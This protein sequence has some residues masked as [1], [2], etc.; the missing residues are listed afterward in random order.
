PAIADIKNR[1][2]SEGAVLSMMSGSGPA[3]FGVFHSAKEAEKASR[4]FEDHW[5][6][7]VQTV[8]D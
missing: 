6:A 2:I 7:V 4:L 1:M 5:T 8:T 3:V